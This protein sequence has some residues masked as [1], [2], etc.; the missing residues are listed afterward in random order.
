[1][2]TRPLSKRSV[3]IIGAAFLGVGLLRRRRSSRTAEQAPTVD[4]LRMALLETGVEASVE[5]RT[6]VGGA[7]AGWIVTVTLASPV[8]AFFAAFGAEAGKDAYA[9][10]RA[11]LDGQGA[12]KYDSSVV[13][14]KGSDDREVEL[15]LPVPAEALDALREVDWSQMP[16]GPMVWD[17]HARCWRPEI[18][19]PKI[20]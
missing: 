18:S 3:P 10:L 16:T 6:V 8:A 15:E 20:G 17:R 19:R 11:W 2:R 14:V 4:A 13:I 1:M 12:G 5:D 7:V 9:A